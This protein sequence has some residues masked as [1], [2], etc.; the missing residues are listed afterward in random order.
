MV[1]SEYCM[2]TSMNE[3]T[4]TLASTPVV[5]RGT[6]NTS[7]GPAMKGTPNISPGSNASILLKYKS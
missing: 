6:P 3:H 7:H 2:N 4:V 1:S 5:L